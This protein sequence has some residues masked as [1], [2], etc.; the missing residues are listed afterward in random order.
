MTRRIHDLFQLVNSKLP[1]YN[2]AFINSRGISLP[3][4]IF[5]SGTVRFARKLGDKFPIWVPH[6]STEL[7]SSSSVLDNTLK[8]TEVLPWIVVGSRL[9]I[10]NRFVVQVDDI[11]DDELT[12]ILT[13]NLITNVSSGAAVELYANPL[14]VVGTF[15]SPV[16]TFVV[17]SPYKIYIGDSIV[18]ELFE[19]SVL[20]AVFVST[21]I[22]G[23]YQYQLTIGD[24]GILDTITDGSTSSIYLRAYPAYESPKMV[25]PT[26]PNANSEIGPFLFDRI[27]GTFYT[28]LDVEEIDLIQ[29]YDQSGNL[30]HTYDAEKNFFLY[31]L[32]I[33]ADS[34]L[35]WDKLRGSL[36]WQKEIKSFKAISDKDGKFHLKYKCVPVIEPGQITSWQVKVTPSV[37]TRMAVEL[38]PNVSQVWDLPGGVSSTVSIQFPI[39]SST[40]EYI[41][42]LFDTSSGNQEVLMKSWEISALPIRFI[43]HIT[44]A[45]V[46]G[47]TWASASAYAKPVWM[48]LDYLMASTDISSLLDGGLL[49]A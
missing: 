35:F 19:F 31:Q 29:T 28:D 2:S 37:S 33:S 16:T 46:F 30:L 39:T 11:F 25:I 36:T 3:L 12:V 43:S 22:D 48:K 32:P 13:E 20:S 1:S 18:Y 7:S 34:F 8:F 21:L 41:H 24:G 45:K 14:E 10:D 47:R 38:E 5:L 9:R 23:R 42:L 4:D 17:K 40:I 15:P 44:I 26:I 6:N 27:S 49:S